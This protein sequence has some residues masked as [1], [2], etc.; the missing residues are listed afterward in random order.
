MRQW[1]AH[2]WF[3]V[4]VVAL[5]ALISLQLGGAEWV[6]DT[7]HDLCRNMPGYGVVEESALPSADSARRLPPRPAADTGSDR[8]RESPRWRDSTAELQYE[9]GLLRRPASAPK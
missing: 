8:L 9:L 2:N 1:L 4:A 5:L 3:R 6:R 7:W